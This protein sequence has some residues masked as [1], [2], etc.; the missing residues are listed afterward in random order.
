VIDPNTFLDQPA[1]QRQ[2][3]LLR[4]R[5]RQLFLPEMGVAPLQGKENDAT[6]GPIKAVEGINCSAELFAQ[7]LM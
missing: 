5:M 6:G 3:H 2:I 7:N 4:G 1:Y